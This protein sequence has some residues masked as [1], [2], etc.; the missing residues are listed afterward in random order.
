MT[1]PHTHVSAGSTSERRI[2]P[3]RCYYEK[4]VGWHWEVWFCR[5]DSS[6]DPASGATE[7]KASAVKYWRWINAAR[8]ANDAWC[9][10]ND[11]VWIANCRHIDAENAQGQL[12][13]FNRIVASLRYDGP[14]ENS[15]T[16]GEIRSALP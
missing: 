8:A 7:W 3:G 13:A 1:D 6:A 5:S 12:A 11:G 16:V 2:E 4:R 10:F 15:L 14:D 9:A